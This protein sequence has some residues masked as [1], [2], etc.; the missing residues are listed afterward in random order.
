MLPMQHQQRPLGHT[1]PRCSGLG[2]APARRRRYT[3]TLAAAAA[4]PQ[5]PAK[6]PA[7]VY[8]QDGLTSAFLDWARSAGVA[9]DRLRPAQFGGLRGLAASAP[10]SADDLIISVPRPAAL[11]LPPRQRCPCPEYVSAEYWDAAPWFVKLGLRL[12]AEKRR[13]A[14]SALAQYL[15]QLPKSVDTPV[16]WTDDRL[17]QLQ[18]PFLIQKVCGG[19]GA[20]SPT[21]A[22][23]RVAVA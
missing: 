2:S 9:F 17:Q 20:L 4:T 8:L 11:T 16:T 14:G 3:P 10:I 13:G 22:T 5:Q 7:P 1:H 21:G 18:Y 15:Q 6:Q 23:R 19:V 12:L